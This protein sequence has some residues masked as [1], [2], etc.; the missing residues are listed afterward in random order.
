MLFFR[1]RPFH[2]LKQHSRDEHAYSASLVS[3]RDNL[4]YLLG[5]TLL[6]SGGNNNLCLIYLRFACFLTAVCRMT[7]ACAAIVSNF[8]RITGAG[9]Y[10]MIQT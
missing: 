1:P 7:T 5:I 9:D 6:T 2:F 8:G 10:S 4:S 3:V